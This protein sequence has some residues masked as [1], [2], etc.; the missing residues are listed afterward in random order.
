MSRKKAY[1][2]MNT[3]L[4]EEN[5]VINKIKKVDGVTE[6]HM[7]YGVYDLVVVADVK[8]MIDI[9]MAVIEQIR[10]IE[11]IRSTMTLLVANLLPE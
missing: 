7:V 3:E 6:A 4:G 10:K 1:I 2:F 9:R 11:G 8:E 5:E